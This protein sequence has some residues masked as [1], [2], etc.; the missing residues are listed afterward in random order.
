MRSSTCRD[1]HLGKLSLQLVTLPRAV[2]DDPKAVSLPSSLSRLH[3]ADLSLRLASAHHAVPDRHVLQNDPRL[4]DGHSLAA[5]LHVLPHWKPS[6]APTATAIRRVEQRMLT[7]IEDTLSSLS[8][9]ECG[10]NILK[11]SNRSS[12]QSFVR[13]D[14]VRS[15]LL[16]F[17]GETLRTIAERMR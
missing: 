11:T 14:A 1:C 7:T 9:T 12:T 5:G 8:R 15:K 13:R 3:A 4:D 17:L 2:P 10:R 16:A 6:P